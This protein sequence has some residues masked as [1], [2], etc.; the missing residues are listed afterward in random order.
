MQGTS[1]YKDEALQ[2]A[3]A[4][5]KRLRNPKP[6]AFMTTSGVP[7]EVEV[8]WPHEPWAGRTASFLRTNVRDLRDGKLARCFVVCIRTDEDLDT[9]V[10]N[11]HTL[12][13]P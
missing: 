9:L 10:R 12:G 1:Q 7:L 5:E 13:T 8:F 2:F 11:R 3:R 4:L 6:S